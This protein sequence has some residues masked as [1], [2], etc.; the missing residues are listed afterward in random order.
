MA[1]HARAGSAWL[2]TFHEKFVV[3]ERYMEPAARRALYRTAA[4]LAVAGLAVFVATLIGVLHQDGLA[5]VD[6][7]EETWLLTIREESLTVA[8]IVLAVVFGPVALPIIILVVTVAWGI[9]AKHAWR[10]LLL[11]AAMLTGVLLAQI[12]TRLVGRHRPPE[13]LM[14]FGPDGSFSFPSGHVLGAA[15]FLLVTTFLVFSRHR[16]PK[17]AAASFVVAVI[18]I[19]LIAACRLYLGY[20]WVS[21]AIASVSL[22]LMVLGAV[23]AV[24]TW[25]TARVPGE[26]VTGVLSGEPPSH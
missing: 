26:P 18:G 5:S 3:E 14:L 4:V 9:L 16:N 6:Q 12:I 10:P 19:F 23:I 13:N 25:R 22:S 7:A 1:H 21:D 24:D 2:R 17:A 15:D 11:A 8:M 20:H